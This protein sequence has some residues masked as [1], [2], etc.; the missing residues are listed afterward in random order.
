M[1]IPANTT[2]T[3]LVP[4]G[5]AADVTESGRPLARAPGVKFLRME[6]GQAVLA[7]GS[8]SYH[9]AS[10]TGAKAAGQKAEK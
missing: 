2:A 8:G 3:V 1:T 4:A 7:I 6:D 5:N 10:A 9:F